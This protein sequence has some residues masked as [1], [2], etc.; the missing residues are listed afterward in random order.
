MVFRSLSRAGSVKKLELLL[1][2]PPPAVHWLL[3]ELLRV[4]REGT[5]I[6]LN[7]A[8]FSKELAHTV[9]KLSHATA[10]QINIRVANFSG[11]FDQLRRWG[12][13]EIKPSS[14]LNP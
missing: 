10:G 11:S 1:Y 8:L 6:G 7:Y 9:S 12:G 4:F 2:P 3:S 5:D 13:V 14:P